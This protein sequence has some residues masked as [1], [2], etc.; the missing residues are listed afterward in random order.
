MSVETA[1]ALI[2]EVDMDKSGEIDFLEMVCRCSFT[3]NCIKEINHCIF[4]VRVE[5]HDMMHV[6]CVM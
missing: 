3:C 6:M 2:D 1:R 4:T 5:W